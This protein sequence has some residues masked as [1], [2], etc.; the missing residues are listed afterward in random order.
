MPYRIA[1]VEDAAYI[2]ANHGKLVSDY[3]S[4]AGSIL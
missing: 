1:V 4:L 3:K 2:L